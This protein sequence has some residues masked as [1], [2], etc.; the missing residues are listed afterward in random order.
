MKK[1]LKLFIL[2]FITNS[3]LAQGF[4][5]LY[6]EYLGQVQP[7]DT[8]VVFARGIVSTKMLEHSAPV[9][10]KD[11]KEFFWSA[12]AFPLNDN[13]KTIYFC[14]YKNGKW[15]KPTIST[16]SGQYNDDSPF[17]YDNKI[18]FSSN[19]YLNQLSDSLN[20]LHWTSKPDS[21]VW[22]S[23]LID[24][25][26]TE[27]ILF[28]NAF[29]KFNKIMNLQFSSNGNMYFSGHLEGV[30]NECG[31]FRSKLHNGNYLSP[32]TLPACIN[33]KEAQDWTPYIASDESYIIFSSYRAGG[34][35][36]GDLYIS[37]YD[38]EDDTWSEPVNMGA[39]INTGRQE[40]F[41]SVSP[42]GKYLFFTRPTNGNSQDVFW[43]KSDII[44][45]LKINA[46]F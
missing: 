27:P 45:E 39:P 13:N 15:T 38:L 8:P 28:T 4:T 6:G 1:A 9:F 24:N 16:F 25:E 18:F 42:D 44:E 33:S 17:Y 37:F 36:N 31:I 3:A 46:E 19:R 40:R 29:D 35:G 43:V 26:W 14:N 41:P 10:T 12:K 32:D 23:E 21:R 22:Y 11:M 20:S 34:F 7:G 5:D 2:I 30:P